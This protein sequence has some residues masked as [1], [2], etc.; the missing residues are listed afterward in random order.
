M[1]DDLDMSWITA[2]VL[3]VMLLAEGCLKW[4]V[5]GAQTRLGKAGQHLQRLTAARHLRCP[6]WARYQLVA[7]FQQQ[8]ALTLLGI[9]QV[10]QC[11]QKRLLE[12]GR[13]LYCT[14][15]VSP[16]ACL[17]VRVVNDSKVALV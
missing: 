16:T 9:R 10:T 15:T 8:R 14:S 11:Y 12:A 1:L 17:T 7:T 4:H 13:S 6:R 3:V 2:A 5:T